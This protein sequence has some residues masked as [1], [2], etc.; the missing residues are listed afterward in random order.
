MYDSHLSDRKEKA[1]ADYIVQ[2]VSFLGIINDY[3]HVKVKPSMVT[4][5]ILFLFIQG[6]HRLS[7][8]CIFTLIAY[9]CIANTMCLNQTAPLGAV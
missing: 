7:P 4:D 1:L 2:M 9:M 8:I 6:N 3:S 5:V